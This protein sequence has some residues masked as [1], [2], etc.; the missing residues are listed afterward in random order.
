MT[1][2]N[3]GQSFSWIEFQQKHNVSIGLNPTFFRKKV[4]EMRKNQAEE[5]LRAEVKAGE[6]RKA[7]GAK[8]TTSHLSLLAGAIKRKSNEDNDPTR[9]KCARPG[10]FALDTII[11]FSKSVTEIMGVRCP[12]TN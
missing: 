1:A 12:P 5:E 9:T 10:Q 7:A 8:K 4:S 11:S 6:V 2:A 3:V